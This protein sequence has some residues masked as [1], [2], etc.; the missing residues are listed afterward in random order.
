MELTG[1]AEQAGVHGEEVV[2]E[3][4]VAGVGGGEAGGGETETSHE[5]SE[6]AREEVGEE[7]RKQD[8]L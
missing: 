8:D 5:W 3:R 1:G 2:G 4:G 6:Q 7:G